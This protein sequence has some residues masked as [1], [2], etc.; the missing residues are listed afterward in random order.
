MRTDLFSSM[1]I[2]PE[3]KVE[4]DLK[5]TSEC[6]RC[7]EINANYPDSASDVVRRLE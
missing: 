2:L 5:E 1:K 3:N 7:A 6:V 4:Q